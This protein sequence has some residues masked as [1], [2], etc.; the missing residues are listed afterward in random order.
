MRPREYT[1]RVEIYQQGT[2]DDGFGGK[3]P[4]AAVLLE[5]R[6][7]KVSKPSKVSAG[8]LRTDYGLDNNQRLLYF[9][10]RDFTGFDRKETYLTYKGKDYR[11]L[12]TQDDDEYGIDLTMIGVEQ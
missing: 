1:K 12:V 11:V 5:T 7:C 4:G 8:Q 9:T 2:T 6:W 3:V 10:F